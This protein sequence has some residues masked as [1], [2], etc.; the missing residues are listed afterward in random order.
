MNSAHAAS[1]KSQPLS[2]TEEIHAA[3]PETYWA[4]LDALKEQYPEWKFVAFYTGLQWEE[5]FSENAEAYPSRNLAYGYSGGQLYFP[6]SWYSTDISGAYNWAANDWTKYDNGS[7]LQASKEAI[8]YCM[9][10]R[11]FLDDVQIFQFLDTAS[12]LDPAV[13]ER[14]I[15]TILKSDHYKQ[16][17]EAADLYD[18][19]DEEGNK[20]YLTFP[21]ALA[22]IGAELGLNQITLASRLYQENSSGTSPLVSG[23]REF[24][25]SDGKVTSGYYNYF[26][27][28]ASG[29]SNSAIIENGLQ[30]AYKN[31]WDN[32]YKSLKGGAEEIMKSFVNRGQTTTYSQKF[33]VDS[34]SSRLYWGQ[35]MQN[36]TAPQTESQNVQ[37]AFAAADALHADLTFV[38]PVFGN[39]PQECPRP[40]KDGNPNYKL[41]SIY[42][43]G[44]SVRNF[45]MDTLEYTFTT[46]ENTLRINAL[47]YA[48][49]TSISYIDPV[50]KETITQCGKLKN[51]IALNSG[52]NIIELTCTAENGDVRVYTITVNSTYV[53]E[54]TKPI[55][56]VE[57]E[58]TV[59]EAPPEVPTEPPVQEPEPTVPETEPETE[60]SKPDINSP[61][62]PDRGETPETDEDIPA[63]ENCLDPTQDGSWDIFDV[64]VIYS[65]ILGTAQLDEQKLALCDVNH[66]NSIDIFDASVIYQHIL[67][68]ITL[69]AVK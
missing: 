19:I 28:G 29:N 68:H 60:P 34:S 31:G 44:S 12:A 9:D 59:P 25:T 53:P 16:S 1:S 32:R 35:Y 50:N 27:I 49:T 17:G 47:A 23:T 48:E 58:P 61:L 30:T 7:W 56:P 39:M 43:D 4:G 2:T 11:N 42:I 62:F 15:N 51:T 52:N 6:T 13:A 38:I 65:H 64:A 36:I 8:A 46:T 66:D 21:Q 26:N 67:G 40:T 18:V 22:Q 33:S 5:L 63:P 54:T 45:N 3:F 57:P 24:S 41:G 55:E 14:A 20:R 10:P 69:R 37:K